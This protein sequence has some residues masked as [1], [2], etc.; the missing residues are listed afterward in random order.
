MKMAKYLMKGMSPGQMKDLLS[1][2]KESKTMM[3]DMIR[4]IVQEEI[5]KKNLV[6]RE[7]VEKM[8]GK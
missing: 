2:A 7:D 6:S 4:K 1:Q 8:L 3:E 5:A